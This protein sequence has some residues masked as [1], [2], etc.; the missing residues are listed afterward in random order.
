[1]VAMGHQ[2]QALVAGFSGRIRRAKGGVMSEQEFRVGDR[3]IC[4]KRQTS[5]AGSRVYVSPGQRGTVTHVGFNSNPARVC[6]DWYR[7]RKWWVDSDGIVPEKPKK[8]HIVKRRHEHLNVQLLDEGELRLRLQ[9]IR[10][11]A[12]TVCKVKPAAVSHDH[13]IEGRAFCSPGDTYSDFVGERLSKARALMAYAKH[14][15]ETVSH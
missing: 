9:F 14:L 1:M 6:V 8:R 13:G 12:M 15:E 7:D 5:E 3:V 11:G 10:V 4:T 2:A